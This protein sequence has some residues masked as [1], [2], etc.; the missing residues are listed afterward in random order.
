LVNGSGTNKKVK[1]VDTGE[2]FDSIVQVALKHKQHSSNVSRYYI[3]GK[4]KLGGFTYEK[5]N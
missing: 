3:D 2:I 1:C 4:R 5:I